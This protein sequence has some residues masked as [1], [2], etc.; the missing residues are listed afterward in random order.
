MY[1]AARNLEL[2]KEETNNLTTSFLSSNFPY[3]RYQIS[4]LVP[5]AVTPVTLKSLQSGILSAQSC[6]VMMPAGAVVV[7]LNVSRMVLSVGS[8]ILMVPAV[9]APLVI[10]TNLAIFRP[11]C[12]RIG[13][14][15][16]TVAGRFPVLRV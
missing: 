3:A 1:T 12:L 4:N 5:V 11:N 15:C 9:V 2:N 13:P 14:G 6:V 7:T 16:W 10:K 8:V